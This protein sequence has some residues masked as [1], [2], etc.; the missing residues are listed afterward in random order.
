[1]EHQVAAAHELIDLQNDRIRTV[2]DKSA[3]LGVNINR[4]VRK[5]KME[6]IPDNR[7]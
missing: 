7:V 5:I 2:Q 4:R 1:M 6:W 3:R